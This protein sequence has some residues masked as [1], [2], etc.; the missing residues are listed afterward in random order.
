VVKLTSTGFSNTAGRE[1][2]SIA[3]ATYINL[4]TAN[5]QQDPEYRVPI[6]SK[7]K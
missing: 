6:P 3:V 5:K 4:S 2:H 7:L 1:L